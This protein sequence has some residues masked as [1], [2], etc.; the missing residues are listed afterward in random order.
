MIYRKGEGGEARMGRDE[1]KVNNTFS[2]RHVLL[3]FF[4]QTICSILNI[5]M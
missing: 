5:K 4:L 3:K 2:L 1:I